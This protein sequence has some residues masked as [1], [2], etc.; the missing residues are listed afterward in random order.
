MY[1]YISKSCTSIHTSWQVVL[2]PRSGAAGAGAAAAAA[3]AEEFGAR[4]RPDAVEAVVPARHREARERETK[5][6]EGVLA[7]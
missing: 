5:I 1:P 6:E 7:R 3:R 4:S 2:S